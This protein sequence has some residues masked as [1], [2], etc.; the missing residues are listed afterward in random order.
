MKTRLKV[1]VVNKISLYLLTGTFTIVNNTETPAVTYTKNVTDQL[2][3]TDTFSLVK[4]DYVESFDYFLSDY[5][6]TVF[7]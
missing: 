6:G 7:A 3:I 4:Q 1:E 5:V 2:N